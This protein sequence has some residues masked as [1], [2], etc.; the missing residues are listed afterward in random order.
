MSILYGGIGGVFSAAAMTQLSFDNGY[1]LLSHSTYY[2]GFPLAYKIAIGGYQDYYDWRAIL[3][4]ML[5]MNIAGLIGVLIAIGINFRSGRN[6][7]EVE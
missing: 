5:F 3:F 4:D 7:Q 1:N 2:T 6:V